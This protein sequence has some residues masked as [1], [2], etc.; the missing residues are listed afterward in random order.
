MQD[1]SIV[2]TGGWDGISNLKNDVWQFQPSGSPAQNPSYI[3]TTPGTYQVALKVF[4]ADGYNS[5]LKTEYITVTGISDAGVFR[6]SSGNWYLNYFNNG[7]VNKAFHFGTSGDIAVVGD[8]DGNGFSDVGI[9]R[10]SNG[11]WYLD[12]TGTG[13]VNRTFHFGTSG[14][15]PIV[16]DWDGN[17]IS[18]V[19]VFR[20]SNGNWYLDTTKTGVVNKTFHFGKAGDNPVIGKWI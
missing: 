9:F 14:D 2:L 4:N 13:V 17:G 8:W 15:I 20:P 11:N 6:P 19:G 18:D 10:P 3:Y 12:T 1:G 16:G 5:T 7:A